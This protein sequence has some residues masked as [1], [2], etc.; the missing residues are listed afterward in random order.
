MSGKSAKQ[1]P[2]WRRNLLQ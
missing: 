2:W 1:T